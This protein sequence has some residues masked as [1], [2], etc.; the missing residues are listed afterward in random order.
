M[1]GGFVRF[2]LAPSLCI[3]MMLASCAHASTVPV[4]SAQAEAD[5]YSATADDVEDYRLGVGDK[6]KMTT[7]N[8]PTLSGDFAVSAAGTISLPLIGAVPVLGKTPAEVAALVQTRLA[9]G[10]LRDPK[11]SVEVTT[12]RPFFILGEVKTPGQ[13]PYA[14]GLTVMN[15][16]ATAEGF[17][18]RSNR[19][20]VYIR[21]SG[22]TTEKAFPLAPELKVLPGDTIRL[23]E[24]YF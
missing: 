18:P 21:R 16:I 19:K 4:A 5:R 1:N 8:E 15:A 13:Y 22:S 17:T 2:G 14:S 9:D 24:R 10:Y 12:Y 6:L 20:T 3:T 23:G 11:I 7:F